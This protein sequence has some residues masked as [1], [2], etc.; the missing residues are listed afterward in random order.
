MVM[1]SAART[2]QWIQQRIVLV[3]ITMAAVLLLI[4][5]AI[6]ARNYV[7]EPQLQQWVLLS[8]PFDGT[9]NALLVEDPDGVRVMYAGTE[10]GVWKSEDQGE[11]WTACN[12]GLTDLLVRSLAM[13]PDNPNILYAG[14]WTGKVFMTRDGGKQWEERSGGLLPYPYEIRSLAVHAHDPNRLYALN[15]VDVL[16]SL[17]RAEQWEPGGEVIDEPVDWGAT[18][19]AGT[20]QCM[21]V[22]PEHPDTVYVGT[23]AALKL[24]GIY[25]SRDAGATWESLHTGLTT[26][27][28]PTFTNVSALVIVPR[29]PGTLY[30]IGQTLNGMRVFKTVNA[31]TS[32]QYV[33]SYR[34]V[35]VPRCIAVNPKNPL[36]VYVGLQ[37]GLHKSTDG[38]KSW[39]RS[40]TGLRGADGSSLDVHIVVVDPI[41]PSTVYACSGNQLFISENAGQTWRLQS[42]ISANAKASILTLTADPKNGQTFYA[43]VESGG[44]YKTSD[45][46]ATW[47]HAGEPLP[48]ERITSLDIDPVN[49]QNVYVGYTVRGLGRVARSTDGGATWP[50]TLTVAITEAEISALAVD[51]EQPTRVYAGTTGR[52]LFRSDDAAAS[53]TP[54]GT[55]LGK[56]VQRIVINTKVD[57]NPVYAL[58]ENGVFTSLDQGDGWA[59][60]LPAIPWIIDIA[61]PFKSALAPIQMTS[62]PQAYVQALSAQAGQPNLPQTVISGQSVDAEANLKALTTG[63]AMPEAVYVL[64]QGKGL[65]VREHAAARWTMAGTGLGDENLRLQ[66]LALSPDDPELILVGTDKGIYRYK[67]DKT[68]QETFEQRLQSL[69]DWLRRLLSR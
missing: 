47:T 23:T 28:Y 50:L 22:D 19:M 29:A 31:G 40:E 67:A 56:S 55:E 65:F 15:S 60:R 8:A 13:D 24:T 63:P 37:N 48:A 42:K 58:T 36:E 69:R 45:G 62:A 1:R 6:F 3:A 4:P 59:S 43:S 61:P 39:A 54:T 52:G 25:V 51:P 34:D 27:G 30:A 12:E 64:A 20:L 68:L 5:A 46:G 18:G 14:T 53:W 9:I 49:T 17:S 21:A 38:R 35:A 11:H 44:L 32:W 16:T 57:Q 10:G 66:A 33:D 26:T 41:Q 7:R 2:I